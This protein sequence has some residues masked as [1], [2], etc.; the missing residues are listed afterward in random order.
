M[1]QHCKL[2]QKTHFANREPER[3]CTLNTIALDLFCFALQKSL[4]SGVKWRM[5]T[6]FIDIEHIMHVLDTYCQY[7]LHDVH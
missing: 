4:Q 6:V 1:L 2:S 5:F 7:S 3:A